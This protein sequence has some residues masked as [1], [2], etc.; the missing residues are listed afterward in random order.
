MHSLIYTNEHHSTWSKGFWFELFINQ[1]KHLACIKNIVL[2]FAFSALTLIL[3]LISINFVTSQQTPL[4]M[5]DFC[6]L[7][8]L[9][10][11]T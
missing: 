10:L 4:L 11:F 5:Q 8:C 3:L 1:T 7:S 9:L 6:S 2:K